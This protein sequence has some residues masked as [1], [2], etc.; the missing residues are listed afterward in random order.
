MIRRD[1]I[2]QMAGSFLDYLSDEELLIV[3]AKLRM[4]TGGRKDVRIGRMT[5][6]LAY[7]QP[8]AQSRRLCSLDCSPYNRWIGTLVLEQAWI[9]GKPWDARAG[10]SE[11]DGCYEQLSNERGCLLSPSWR[12][13]KRS[14]VERCPRSLWSLWRRTSRR[15]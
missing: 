1:P 7:G 13:G 9:G 15:T 4:V 10:R 6:A 14:R 11:R 5:T 8:R 2:A 3:A 12:S